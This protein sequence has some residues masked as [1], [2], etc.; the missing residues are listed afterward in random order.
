MHAITMSEERSH[1]FEEESEWTYGMVWGEYC[2]YIIISRIKYNFK[3][4]SELTKTT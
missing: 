3:R 1:E 4:K 2:K